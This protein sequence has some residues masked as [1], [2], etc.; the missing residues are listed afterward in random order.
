MARSGI[1]KSDVVN[2]RDQLTSRGAYA[3]VDAIRI[4][5]GNTGSKATI[6]RYLKKIEQ[7][8]IPIRLT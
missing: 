2:V 8:D 7:E 5:M 4:E 1:C 3:S 6:H